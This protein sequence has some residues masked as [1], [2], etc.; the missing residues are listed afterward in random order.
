E[1]HDVLSSNTMPL[2]LTILREKLKS[3]DA[4]A[5]FEFDY[6]LNV[7]APVSKLEAP[8]RY[9]CAF[10]GI[11][12]NGSYDFILEVNVIA[13]SVC[14][15]SREMSLLDNLEYED[16]SWHLPVNGDDP[17]HA[18]EKLTKK[19]FEDASNVELS[20]QVG[21]GA[22]NQR[23]NIKVEI[24]AKEGE[25]IWIEDLISLVESQASCPV[26]PILKRPDE[27][28]VTEHGYNNA[29]FSED[30]TRDIH[31]A[32]EKLGTIESWNLKISNE[33]SIHIYNAV[34]HHSSENWKYHTTT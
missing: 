5:R 21:Q 10:T 31:L 20:L 34:C 17:D 9:R 13:A 3:K 27:K 6:Y 12:K 23:S 22:H 24:I 14:P 1:K 4:Y 7:K 18:Y 16:I 32:L 11:K 30:I 15:C 8:Q 33:E 25:I 29:K 28:W 26:Y 2:L 19:V